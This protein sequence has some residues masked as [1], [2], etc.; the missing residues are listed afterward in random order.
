MSESEQVAATPLTVTVT[1]VLPLTLDSGTAQV[2]FVVVTSFGFSTQ[3]F[4]FTFTMFLDVS[5]AEKPIPC[6]YRSL[7]P[8][9]WK[10]GFLSEY[11]E[12]DADS[13]RM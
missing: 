11:W 8:V 9:Y 10:V 12:L 6:I 4:S 1:K 3:I 7:P 2:I 5:G 13:A